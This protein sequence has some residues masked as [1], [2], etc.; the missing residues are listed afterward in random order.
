MP[1]PE[2]ASILARTT[3][4]GDRAT[5]PGRAYLA[6]FGVDRSAASAA[7]L[8]RHVIESTLA[9]QAG[10]D[11][12]LPALEIVL[13]HGCLARRIREAVGAQPS[14]GRVLATYTRLCGC[15]ADG[16]IFRAADS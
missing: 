10:G 15:L 9:R 16:T 13:D 6:L 1:T 7:E 5:I 8:W 12:W 2:L 3:R 11:E 14:R 4:S